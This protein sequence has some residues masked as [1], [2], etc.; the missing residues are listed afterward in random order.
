MREET[1]TFKRSVRSI[2][3]ENQLNF[4]VSEHLSGEAQ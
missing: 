4:A 3:N 2:F 1:M